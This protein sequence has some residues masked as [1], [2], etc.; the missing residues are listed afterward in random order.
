MFGMVDTL[1]V[2]SNF[3]SVIDAITNIQLS[4]LIAKGV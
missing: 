1:V 3:G 4:G 2:V